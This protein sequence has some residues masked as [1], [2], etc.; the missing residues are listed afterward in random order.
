LDIRRIRRSVVL[1]GKLLLTLTSTVILGFGS[2]VTHDNIFLSHD[3]GCSA[4][5]LE[6][7]E[8]DARGQLRIFHTE[9]LSHLY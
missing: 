5:A 8:D 2:R 7:E 6:D 1:L 4:T 9:T 3:S